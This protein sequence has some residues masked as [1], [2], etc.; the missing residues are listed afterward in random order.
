MRAGDVVGIVVAT[1][2]RWARRRAAL[3]TRL[4]RAR[5][6]KWRGPGA[7]S[8]VILI[9]RSAEKDLAVGSC[10]YCNCEV[11]RRLRGSG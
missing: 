9:R 10:G 6:A 3:R 1:P 11:P 7:K 8:S 5:R 2:A 4:E